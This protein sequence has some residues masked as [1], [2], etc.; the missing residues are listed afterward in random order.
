MPVLPCP[1]GYFLSAPSRLLEELSLQSCLQD[2]T[3]PNPSQYPANI[4]SITLVTQKLP[5]LTRVL[6]GN[7]FGLV[8]PVPQCQWT[9]SSSGS[10]RQGGTGEPRAGYTAGGE[11]GAQKAG[12]PGVGN[13]VEG[14]GMMT[15]EEAEGMGLVTRDAPADTICQR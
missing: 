7:D 11:V 5:H 6:T 9:R 12:D 13:G 4:L 10:D 1:R 14:S 15:R 8:I 2:L 3:P